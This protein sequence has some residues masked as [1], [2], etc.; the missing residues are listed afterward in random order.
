MRK[1]VN[2]DI[3]KKCF[4]YQSPSFLAKDL[5]KA[6]PDKNKQIVNQVSDTLIGLTNVVNTKKLTEIKNSDIVIKIME[7]HH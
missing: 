4:W 1:T 5:Y 7:K 2:N 3:F 6:N